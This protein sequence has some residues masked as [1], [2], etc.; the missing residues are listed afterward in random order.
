MLKKEEDSLEDASEDDI[1]ERKTKRSS[2]ITRGLSGKKKRN[3]DSNDILTS[4][5]QRASQII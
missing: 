2:K 1:T 3:S 5:S 4:I